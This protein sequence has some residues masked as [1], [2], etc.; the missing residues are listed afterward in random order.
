MVSISIILSRVR[1][2]TTHFFGLANERIG[3]MRLLVILAGA[4]AL[5]SGSVSAQSGTALSGT[6]TNGQSSQTATR[7]PVPTASA[8]P[9][10][11]D[12]PFPTLWDTLLKV[13]TGELVL[14]FNFRN[15]ERLVNANPALRDL[16]DGKAPVPAENRNMTWFA[17]TDDAWT[18]MGREFGPGYVQY[19]ERLSA[20]LIKWVTE[21]SSSAGPSS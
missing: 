10:P 5:F 21:D 20:D 11:A 17:F 18:A 1:N 13:T 14:P 16:L 19:V 3:T 15:L 9:N 7:I 6:R 2:T 4:V 8:T 12:V